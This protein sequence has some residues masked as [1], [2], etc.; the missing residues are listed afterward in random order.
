M[1]PH[2]PQNNGWM[3]P[4]PKGMW[5]HA[6]EVEALE[7][8]LAKLEAENAELRKDRDEWRSACVESDAKLRAYTGAD[9]DAPH[10]EADDIAHKAVAMLQEQSIGGI[11]IHMAARSIVA[12]AM[13]NHP[14]NATLDRLREVAFPDGAV[15]TVDQVSDKYFAM[16]A[17]LYP[18]PDVTP[19]P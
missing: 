9:L 7:A 17:I 11:T 3:D 6:G 18:T 1:T 8:G 10:T 4:D 15:L 14:A 19:C 16:Q 2:A 12:F 5:F 13:A